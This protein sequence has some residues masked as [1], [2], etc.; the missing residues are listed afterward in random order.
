MNRNEDAFK[1][2][3]EGVSLDLFCYNGGFKRK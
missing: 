3:N 2:K 1:R